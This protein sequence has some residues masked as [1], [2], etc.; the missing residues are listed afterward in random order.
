MKDPGINDHAQALERETNTREQQGDEKQKSDV[1]TSAPDS[2]IVMKDQPSGEEQQEVTVE[3]LEAQLD[4]ELREQE[5]MK[6]QLRAQ[7]A[8]EVR[9]EMEAELRAK[10]RAE[11]EAELRA[12][13]EQVEESEISEEE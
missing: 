10:V 6:A 8:A 9:A 1:H 7:M 3:V 12:Q 4:Q 2:D 13:Q 11:F 5:E